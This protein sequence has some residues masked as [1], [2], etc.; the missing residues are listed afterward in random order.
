VRRQLL[1]YPG[2]LVGGLAVAALATWLVFGYALW[3][4][5]DIRQSLPDR[6][7]LQ[8]VGD[9]AQST[10]LYDA[11]DEPV[12]TIFKEQRIEVPLAKISA[13]MKA[14]V[15]SVED[16]RFYQHNGVDVVRIGAA[17]IANARSGRRS[18]G[19]STI[20]QQL[21]RQSFLTR[22]KTYTRKVKEAFAALLIERTYTKD[23][24]LEL[25][26]N[27]VYFGDGFH[28]VEAA[29]RG[30]FGKTAAALDGA[31]AAL[32]AGLIQSPSAYAPT[33]SMEK[34]VARRA[35]V[36]RTMVDTGAIDEATFE[37]ALEAP[38]ELRNGAGAPRTG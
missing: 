11:D 28:G 15:L 32:L 4:A 13:Q 27:K 16:Q 9:M 6:A 17:A 18:Q 31:E 29:S 20:T 1:R 3:L 7:A 23:E 37:Q 25:Y 2:V 8:S 34:A 14:A 24:I 36:L 26:L 5:W 22:H 33:I 35:V 30:F 19:G 12:F 38:V 10:T 21:A